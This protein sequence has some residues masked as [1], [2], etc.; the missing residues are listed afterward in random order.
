MAGVLELGID[1]GT[2]FSCIAHINDSGK[3]VDTGVLDLVGMRGLIPS[4][5]LLDDES[6]PIEFGEL[7]LTKYK[8]GS[9]KYL[10]REFKMKLGGLLI[11]KDFHIE[12]LDVYEF[13]LTYLREQIIENYSSIEGSRICVT[14]PADKSGR[15]VLA[16]RVMS[17]AEKVFPGCKILHIDEPSAVVQYI[18]SCR[19]FLTAKPQNILVIDSGGGTTDYA[20]A[21]AKYPIAFGE[22]P[23]E[24]IGTTKIDIGGRNVDRAIFKKANKGQTIRSPR[25]RELFLQVIRQTKDHYSWQSGDEFKFQLGSSSPLKKL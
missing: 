5:V 6:K 4:I 25:H 1:I 8:D 15:D 16:H 24:I 20:L 21:T 11:E 18:D 13:F 2:T 9:G 12:A 10:F 14:H 17:T 7:A 19:G 23:L 22:K 3:E